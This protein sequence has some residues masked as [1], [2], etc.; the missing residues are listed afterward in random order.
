ML[1]ESWGPLFAIMQINYDTGYTGLIMDILCYKKI[2]S[3]SG[4]C[5]HKSATNSRVFNTN[6]IHRV[7]Y[8]SIHSS[9]DYF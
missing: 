9:N 5:T 8:V 7:P 2:S 3:P 6:V 4:E 1:I